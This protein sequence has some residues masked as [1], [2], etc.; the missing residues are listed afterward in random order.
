MVTIASTWNDK[1]AKP[2]LSQRGRAGLDMLGN[3]QVWA[4]MRLRP[5]AEADFLADEEGAALNAAHDS[6]REA[7]ADRLPCAR[8]TAQ[9]SAAYR[10]D[11][12]VQRFV[13][14]DIWRRAIPAIEARREQFDAF[15][16]PPSVSVGGTL[17]GDA[18]LAMPL[19]MQGWDV[20][21][22]PGGF[23]GYDLRG[24]AFVH[25]IGP[26]I[27]RRGG[28]ASVSVGADIYQSRLSVLRQLPRPHYDRIYEGG[29]GGFA[30]LK[31]I[32]EVFPQAELTGTDLSY[33]QLRSS[34]IQAELSGIKVAYKQ[35]DIRDTREP[36]NSFDAVVLNN[37]LHEQPREASL[38]ILTEMLRILKPGGDLVLADPAPFR[39]VPLFNAVLLDWETDHRGEPYFSEALS[40]DWAAEM[41]RIGFVDTENRMLGLGM[42]PY[43]S[44]GRKP[45]SEA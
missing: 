21:L 40:A 44:L 42:H 4:A 18:D 30:T 17:E 32:A 31:A 35:R 6:D 27:F 33:R 25:G 23:D 1:S 26:K 43:I 45:E 9:R 28:Y 12:M 16:D 15:I 39:A 19:F 34:H 37:V 3:L 7:F 38:A 20:H 2:G 5:Q 29:C 13:A 41:A 8:A 24:A 11:R 36:D 14:E 10:V 22:E